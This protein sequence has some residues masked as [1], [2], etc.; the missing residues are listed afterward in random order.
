MNDFEQAIYE[1]LNEKET[2]GFCKQY[3]HDTYTGAYEAGLLPK[4][5]SEQLDIA[6]ETIEDLEGHFEEL[7][8][9][10]PKFTRGEIHRYT[11]RGGMNIRFALGDTGEFILIINEDEK[12]KYDSLIL[13]A[14]TTFETRLREMLDNV[15]TYGKYLVYE[16]YM[17]VG[18]ATQEEI[19]SA[20]V[21][22]EK[23]MEDFEE[24][25]GIKFQLSWN[26]RHEITLGSGTT[27]EI[28]YTNKGEYKE[29]KDKETG[30]VYNNHILQKY[31]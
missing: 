17:S 25:K 5:T 29:V 16:T 20:F 8:E 23:L 22:L 14:E 31:A 12:I 13:F 15:D 24:L 2:T 10:S 3:V 21:T 26:L 30:T 19:N 18:D 1:Y 27:I 7:R 9:L 4:V 6:I 11:L 28:A